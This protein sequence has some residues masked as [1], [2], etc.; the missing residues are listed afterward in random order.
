MKR[1][2]D[3]WIS[4]KVAKNPGTV[5]LLGIL[6]FNIVF[7]FLSAL[8][9]SSFSMSGTEKMGFFQAA[10]STVSM[11][12]DA[13]CVSYVIEDIGQANVA[14]AL[15][16]LIIVIIGM[17]SFTGAVIGY[18]TNYISGFIDNA[19]SGK[20][21]LK[22]YGHT[23]IINW[24][25]R[26]SEIVND[27]L[28]CDEKKTVVVLADGNRDAIEQEINERI[29]DTVSRENDI[30][31][32]NCED[33]PFFRRHAYYRKNRFKDTVTVIIREGDTFSTKQLTDICIDKAKMVIILNSSTNGGICKYE[34]ARIEVASKEGNSRTIKTLMQVS[35]MTS[36]RKSLDNQKIVV[37]VTDDWTEDI[38]KKI[39]SH[40]QVE[41]KCNIIPIRVNRILG[42][43]LSQFS[44][45]PELNQVY[46]ELMSNRGASFYTMEKPFAC[47]KDF[48]EDHFSD[49]NSGIPLT[50]INKNGKS[51]CYFVADH[52]S[53]ISV[54]T[55]V[56]R[57]GYKAAL[58]LDY[59][60]EH[61][62]VVILGHNNNCKELMRG[63]ESFMAEWG[64]ILR[65]FVIDDQ[66][67]LD[68]MENYAQYPFVQTISANI[69]DRYKIC[70]NIESIVSSNDEDTSIL[71]LSDDSVC[72]DDVDENALA[73]LV[74]VQ[75]IINT[76]R[77]QNP[78]FDEGSIDVIVEI[79]DPKHHDVVENYS[80]NNVVISNRYVSKM[81]TQLAEK[82]NIYDFYSDILTYDTSDGKFESK[83]V[84]AK[85][86]SS[87]FTELPGPCTADE[88]VRAVYDAS[89]KGERAQTLNNPVI[90]LGYVAGDGRVKLFAG[91][92][93][94]INITLTERDKLVVYCA[95]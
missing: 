9:I 65:V 91:D 13:G 22:L 11:I 73:N 84:Y 28:Y 47:E 16:C 54:K 57:T 20:S 61:K 75:D 49:H 36:S 59:R 90:V 21:R 31:R 14:L 74:Y 26:A 67:S 51:V 27:L 18:V 52:A 34:N 62:T 23:V 86:V 37:E 42:R 6:G 80:V 77:K 44:L 38:V 56:K 12:L 30:V 5:V 64:D 32:E 76:K 19:D 10:F 50:V 3:E 81:L 40:K 83:E 68:R 95:H 2:L 33:M 48:I 29:A 1:K 93:R 17:I 71:I 78:D 25:N 58:D 63:F 35:D 60:M 92:L 43:L 79:I 85:K 94:N 24:N 15:I 87:L 55:S 88:L 82:E 53:D 70:S 7:I 4:I 46:G 39:I 72:G 69:Y 45:M 66:K 8:V 89:T 41:G